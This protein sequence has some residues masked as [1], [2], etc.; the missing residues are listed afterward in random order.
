MQ[1]SVSGSGVL[2]N[3]TFQIIRQTQS[4]PITL[5]VVLLEGPNPSIDNNRY[6]LTLK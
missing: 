5:G 4:T 6:S 1:D 2:A 3:M